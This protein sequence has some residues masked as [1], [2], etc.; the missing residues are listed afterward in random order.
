VAQVCP[1]R[2]ARRVSNVS[3]VFAGR[4]SELAVLTGAFTRVRGGS[5]AAML[6]GGEAGGGKTRLI[7]EFT[8]RVEDEALVLAGGCVEMGTADLPYAPFTA[9]LRRLVRRLGVDDV[10][11]L[12]PGGSGRDLARLLPE[13]GAA[14]DDRDTG[15]AQA[16]LFE[17]FLGLFENLAGKEPLV[18]VVEDAHWA[19]RST[20]DLLAFLIRNLRD[21]AVLL[22]VTYRS[23]ELHRKHPLRPVLAELD[24][25]PWVTRVDLRR[26]TR[27]EVAEQLAGI[28]G[29]TPD[30]ELVERAYARADGIPL[31]V[32]AM[33]DADG[34]VVAEIPESLRDLLLGSVHRLPDETQRVLLAAST[35]SS[36]VG[37]GLLAAVTGLDDAALAA[38]VRPA[39]TANVLVVDADGYAY[40][41]ALIGEAVHEEFLPGEHTQT[42]RRFAEA[43]E[44]NPALARRGAA[45]LALHWHCAHDN[46]RALAA[47]WAAA[48]EFRRAFAF[49]ER[50]AMLERVLELWDQV[51][52]AADRIG[53]G[54]LD[55]L[56]AAAGA[57][58]NAGE[59]ARGLGVVDTAL[60]QVDAEQDQERAAR[61][62]VLRGVLRGAHGLPGGL[63]DYRAAERLLPEPTIA[64]ARVLNIL[65]GEL[66]LRGQVAEGLP[67]LTEAIELTERHGHEYRQIDTLLTL[68]LARHDLGENEA[69][70]AAFEEGRR[71]AARL[72]TGR[73]L[74]RALL[75]LADYWNNLGEHERAAEIAQEGIT[76]ARRAGRMRS[77][78]VFA[79]VNLAEAQIPL[80]RWDAA[81]E[82]LDQLSAGPDVPAGLSHM[83]HRL[84][85]E[86]ALGRGETALAERL[87]ADLRQDLATGRRLPQDTLPFAA[88]AIEWRLARDDVAGALAETEETLWGHRLPDGPRLV[89]PVLAVGMR[90]CAADPDGA[91]GLRARL[92]RLAAELA[93][94]TRVQQAY[95]LLFTAES[96][97]DPAS[98][99]AV[100]AAWNELRVPYPEAYAL[101][102]A[103]EAL[104]VAGDREAAAQRLTRAADIAGRLA[105]G[106]LRT[107]IESLARRARIAP[108]GARAE[109]PLGL[110]PRELEVLRLV[111][112]GRSNRDIAAELFIS[113]KTASVH[114]SNILAKLGVARRGEAAAA[115]HRLG[116]LTRGGT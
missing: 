28:L 99:D 88:L 10:V 108:A 15:T 17:Q 105:A 67:L 98:F 70:L 89:W 12:V 49:A 79:A 5:P 78:G 102:R 33:V 114:V 83:A 58:A 20:R 52:D 16:R 62:L 84:R 23:D 27:P 44:A 77:E 82:T 61:L 51:P 110:T 86:I 13:F 55:V 43:L 60:T 73:L 50:L 45:E 103:A 54:R 41:H 36:G 34:R 31:F 80:G 2:H 112:A 95:R 94:H 85:A 3:P 64:R 97:R 92:A 40:R 115:A 69:A 116:L 63:D 25:V 9:I 91:P 90:A 113:A 104:V 57:A 26:L 111:A 38:A 81:L 59:P 37:H 48:A 68:A 96:D 75:N 24:R 109:T 106:P 32:E 1:T 18:L 76:Q 47:A 6:V 4:T 72:G 14:P 71:R 30:P 107:E 46:P 42:H 21:A 100:A 74:P 8:G 35:S 56:E 53:A 22:I 87:I 39:V 29:R 65:A 11:A 66:I 7:T 93:V 19:D 101:L